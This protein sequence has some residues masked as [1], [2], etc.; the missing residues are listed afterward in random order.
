MKNYQL[1]P[2]L[3]LIASLSQAIAGTAPAGNTI[4]ETKEPNS[5][6][7]FSAEW[8]YTTKSNF[9]SGA[10]GSQDAGEWDFSYSHRFPVTGHWYLRAGV[11]YQRFD[12]GGSTNGL[13][14]HLQAVSGI[15]AFEY[16]EQNFPAVAV[17]LHPG[18][19]FENDINAQ[20]F[21]MPI[22]IYSSFKITDRFFV[23]I[24]A[25]GA[26]YYHPSVFPIGGVIW[27]IN[28]QWRVEGIFPKP[29]LIWSPMKEWDF[30][31]QGELL[32]GGFRMDGGNP[33][34]AL[35]GAVLQYVE[36]RA[37]VQASYTGFKSFELIAGAGYSVER[38][39]DFYR[40][41]TNLRTAGALFIKLGVE[42]KF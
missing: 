24:G 11:D 26:R 28:D 36:Y 41:H 3:I 12:F 13:P 9:K 15:V 7:L 10:Y 30:R 18:F 32:G 31:L 25:A 23:M 39:F 22:E 35:S 21:D 17:V 5:L 1:V 8:S 27:L 4:L 38:Q 29:A 33:N 19:Y 20:S 34:P 2:L 37:G 42:A 14:N 40:A 6:D 16:V